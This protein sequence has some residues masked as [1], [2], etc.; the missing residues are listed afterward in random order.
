LDILPV[1]L[2]ERL[3]VYTITGWQIAAGTGLKTQ[4]RY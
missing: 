2:I 4:L 3:S 1:G